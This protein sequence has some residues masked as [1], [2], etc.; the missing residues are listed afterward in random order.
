MVSPLPSR[1]PHARI[2]AAKFFCRRSGNVNS[3]SRNAAS[4]KNTRL[5]ARTRCIMTAAH[6]LRA[7]IKNSGLNFPLKRITVNLAPADLRKEGPAYDLPIAVGVLVASEQ[8]TADVTNALIIGELSLDGAVRH[9]N[10]VLSMA[11][12]TRTLGI[13]TPFVPASDAPRRISFFALRLFST[14][15]FQCILVRRISFLE[16]SVSLCQPLPIPKTSN[17]PN[18]L[19]MSSHCATGLR[20]RLL[21]TNCPNA[22]S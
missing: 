20:K 22:C 21:R 11:L 1:F 3:R 7:A 15:R 10:G 17:L 4:K 13:K 14:P 5:S 19:L 2:A 8:I 6:L 16:N 9:T 18:F 12:L